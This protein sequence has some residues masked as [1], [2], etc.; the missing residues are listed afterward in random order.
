M[1]VNTIPLHLGTSR[2]TVHE[3]SLS[4]VSEMQ[5]AK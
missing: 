5:N 3:A 2:F 1:Q 4:V